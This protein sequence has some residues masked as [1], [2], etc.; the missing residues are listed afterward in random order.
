MR[1]EPRKEK[2]KIRQM[3]YLLFCK[4]KTMTL[5]T[6]ISFLLHSDKYVG[7]KKVDL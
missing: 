4:V 5:Q 6:V 3:R 7:E 1:I 2:E